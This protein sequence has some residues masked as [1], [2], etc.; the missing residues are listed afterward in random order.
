MAQA[1]FRSDLIG[2]RFAGASRFGVGKR[3]LKIARRFNACHYPHL[4]CPC[5]NVSNLSLIFE[6]F[7][8]VGRRSSG[9]PIYEHEPNHSRPVGAGGVWLCATGRSAAQPALGEHRRTFSRQSWRDA[10][11]GFSTLGR[12]E[13]RLSFLRAAWGHVRTDTDT[14]LGAEEAGLPPAGR[15]FTHGGH[16]PFGLQPPRGHRKFGSHWRWGGPGF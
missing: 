1:P 12:A 16:H 4:L 3:R 15:I 6:A 7:G 2:W 13:G 10:A 11:A 8:R 9:R 5:W 14:A